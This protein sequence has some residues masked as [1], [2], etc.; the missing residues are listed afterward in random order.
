MNLKKYFCLIPLLFVSL[1]S[2][3]C[4]EGGS[5]PDSERIKRKLFFGGNVDISPTGNHMGQFILNANKLKAEFD[6][7]NTSGITY[8]FDEMEIGRGN[9]TLR[10]LY[11]YDMH[12][13]KYFFDFLSGSGNNMKLGNLSFEP[14]FLIRKLKF[15]TFPVVVNYEALLQTT[16]AGIAKIK[17]DGL[18]NKGEPPK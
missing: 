1:I 7:K 14:D 2:I 12:G 8:S 4:D 11:F 15:S 17:I 13:Q 6:K 16:P 5:E 10:K 18:V 3:C 9:D